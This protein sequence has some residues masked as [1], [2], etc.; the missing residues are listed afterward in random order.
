MPYFKAKIHQ[1]RF[2]WGSAPD[3]AE[4]AYSAPPGPLAGIEITSLSPCAF[5]GF[6]TV[7]RLHTAAV[8]M[9]TGRCHG[10]GKL[11]AD[12]VLRS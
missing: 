11:C 6:D 5:G 10:A 4:G 3:S 2:G 7:S 9:V 1:I 12:S 8:V